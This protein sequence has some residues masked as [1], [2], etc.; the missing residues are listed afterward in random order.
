MISEVIG[1]GATSGDPTM[2]CSNIG[3]SSTG[4]STQPT[5]SGNTSEL[6]TSLVEMK[7]ASEDLLMP[8]A[9]ASQGE[10]SQQLIGDVVDPLNEDPP[11]VDLM[12]SEDSYEDPMNVDDLPMGLSADAGAEAE[13]AEDQ[14]V[15]A[16]GQIEVCEVA[17]LTGEGVAQ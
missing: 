14:V 2:E 9:V 5:M 1:E 11:T 8:E 16:E 12:D 7:I 10:D 4:C 17:P 13:S 3:D 15:D 6:A